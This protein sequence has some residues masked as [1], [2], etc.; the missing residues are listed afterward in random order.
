MPQ[1]ASLKLSAL[2]VVLLNDSWHAPEHYK[3]LFKELAALAQP[4][5]IR[6]EQYLEMDSHLRQSRGTQVLEGTL[7]RFT[8]IEAMNWYNIEKHR[9]ASDT[10]RK[11]IQVPPNIAAN[12]REIPFAFDLE[13]HS[14]VFVTRSNRS[15]VSAVQ[16][17]KFM[18]QLAAYPAIFK[19]YGTVVA[20]VEQDEEQLDKILESE[21][22]RMLRIT[23][24]RPNESFRKYDEALYERLRKMGARSDTEEFHADDEAA[25]KPDEEAR[26]KAKAAISNGQVDAKVLIDGLVAE[27]STM[28]KPLQERVRYDAKKESLQQ[29][30]L[31]G[32]R[33]LLGRIARDK[34]G[35]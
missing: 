33:S 29:A 6:G 9:R 11:K 17:Q 23:V 32:F 13:S 14:F 15:L 1:T 12:Y 2:N 34:V 27:V 21:S 25:L 16:V 22:I 35:E 20:S 4:V 26:N 8:A 5:P 3:S 30:F 10:E 31:R 28:D 19:I 7:H 18:T 24:N